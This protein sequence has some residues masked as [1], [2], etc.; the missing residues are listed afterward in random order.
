MISGV[1]ESLITQHT[2]SE[3]VE[4]T[5]VYSK[6]DERN[7]MTGNININS[8]EGDNIVQP[9]PPTLGENIG[10][11]RF[12][13]L[14]MFFSIIFEVLIFQIKRSINANIF[15]QCWGLSRTI[16][17]PSL[18]LMLILPVIEFLS[19]LLEYTVVSSTN[20]L[21]ACCLIKLS[22]APE[23]ISE[24]LFHSWHT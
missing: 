23:I 13:D 17:S 14:K 24:S 9:S 18:E 4:L 16:L 21:N 15:T 20:S 10:V 7:S 19:S 12:F 1:S 6:S 22:L 11:D 2:F 8:S 3:L 5:T